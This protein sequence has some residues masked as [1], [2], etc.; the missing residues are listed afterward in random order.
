MI[1]LAHGDCAKLAAAHFLG[2]CNSL[3]TSDFQ[4]LTDNAEFCAVLDDEVMCCEGCGWWVES[5]EIG[6]TGV[7]FD[8]D[9]DPEDGDEE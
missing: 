8:C 6:E 1:V 3:E 4:E 9:P 2:T 5:G 7:C